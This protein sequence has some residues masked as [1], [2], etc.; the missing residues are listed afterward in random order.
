MLITF[1]FNTFSLIMWGNY[2]SFTFGKVNL[3]LN[4]VGALCLKACKEKRL[5]RI[6]LL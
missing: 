5:P 4:I 2:V 3:K 1:S 6:I